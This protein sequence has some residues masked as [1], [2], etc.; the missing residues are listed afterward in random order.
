MTMDRWFVALGGFAGALAVGLGAF[1]AHALRPA[2]D[3]AGT[4]DTY[5]TAVRYLF[6]HALALI[7]VGLASGRWP[8]PMMTAS[9]WSFLVGIALFCGS[10]LGVSLG[11]W[12][13][14]GAVAPIGGAAFILGWLALAIGV[15][16]T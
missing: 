11:G 12:R 6:Y 13:A 3:T 1:G 9:G 8:S 2:L 16:R 4:L 15:L 5:E 7:A 14:L 10:L